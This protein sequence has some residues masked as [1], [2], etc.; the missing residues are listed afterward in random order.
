VVRIVITIVFVIVFIAAVIPS[1]G[2][3][4]TWVPLFGDP[5]P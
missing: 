1:S 4:S 3:V 2:V 5:N